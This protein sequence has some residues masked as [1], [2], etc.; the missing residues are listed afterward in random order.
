MDRALKGA[1]VGS[2]HNGIIDGFCTISETAQAPAHDSFIE[3]KSE[4]IGDACHVSTM[5]EALAFVQTIR[6]QHPKSRHVAFAVIWA[7]PKVGP[8]SG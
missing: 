2:Q 3:K 5:D 8:R 4:F 6:E 1:S 7:P